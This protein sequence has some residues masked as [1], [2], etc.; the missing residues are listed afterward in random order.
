[1][2]IL[3]KYYILKK[4]NS[5]LFLEIILMQV[6]IRNEPGLLPEYL[7]EAHIICGS[8]K[9]Q[10]VGLLAS[11][12]SAQFGHVGCFS[13]RGGG[14]TP[15]FTRLCTSQEMG[16]SLEILLKQCKDCGIEDEKEGSK[17]LRRVRDFIWPRQDSIHRFVSFLAGK[18]NFPYSFVY[19]N[20]EWCLSSFLEFWKY[21]SEPQGPQLWAISGSLRF[22]IWLCKKTWT[23]LFL[24]HC[25]I[26]GKYIQS[27][28][29]VFKDISLSINEGKKE[30]KEKKKRKRE[31]E[32][33][34]Q[35]RHWWLINFLLT[36]CLPK[37]FIG[38]G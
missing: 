38:I 36:H 14:V 12:A 3:L 15:G 2:P 5:F 19:Y 18:L 17:G 4:I 6:S 33:E 16:Y 29:S 23:A 11:S 34:K 27:L 31:M 10:L 7:R 24:V 32:K 35:A 9:P 26:L 20:T 21:Q 25:F 22:S 1:M 13:N 8:G 30:K 28:P 37:C